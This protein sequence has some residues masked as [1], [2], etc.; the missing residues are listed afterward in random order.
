[1]VLM[2]FGIK[3]NSNHRCRRVI[4]ET[5]GLF[6]SEALLM[7]SVTLIVRQ[8]ALNRIFPNGFHFLLED[9]A[10]IL[11]AIKAADEEIMK[12]V[13]RFP[14]EKCRSLLHMVYHPSE[15]RFYKQ[16]AIQ[17]YT[18]SNPF[19]NLRENPRLSLPNEATII[20]IPQG[21]CTTD[22]EEPT[23]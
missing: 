20:L 12:K 18:S 3:L 16:V 17:A 15:N 9:D 19:I 23:E 2:V 21:G 8:T 7:K 1:M 14:I 13:N 22:W 6:Q 5:K 11:D 10:S 4:A